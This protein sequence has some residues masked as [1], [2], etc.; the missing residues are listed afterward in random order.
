ML[1]GYVKSLGVPEREIKE[2]TEFA[3]NDGGNVGHAYPL[4]S[5]GFKIA[6]EGTPGHSDALREAA[7]TEEGWKATVTAAKVVALTAYDLL[8]HPEKVKAIQETFKAKKAK[9]GK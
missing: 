1:L 4:M 6:P 8:I 5:L 2:K 9:E 3:S 7:A